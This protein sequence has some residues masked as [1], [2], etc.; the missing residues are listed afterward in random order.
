M[1]AIVT[2][3][4]GAT[5]TKPSR[6]SATSASGLKVRV[7]YD[8]ALNADDNHKAAALALCAKYGWT[9]E[10]IGGGLSDSSEVWV[11]IPRG[12]KLVE[13]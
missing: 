2:K 8:H 11:M 5:N 10:L 1:Q 12:M 4:H 13:G 3:Y 6:I 7:S 9:N